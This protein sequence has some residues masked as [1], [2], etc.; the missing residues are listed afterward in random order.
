MAS[1]VDLFLDSLV[2]AP[3]RDE[4]A[5]MEFPFFSITKRPQ[6]EAFVY[7]RDDVKIVVSPGPKGMAT[8]WD[9][10]VLIY[11]ASLLNERLER[12]LPADRKVHFAA[13]D[14]LRVTQR[15]TGKQAYELFKDALFRLRSTTVETTIV[16]GGQRNHRG[17]GWIDT[18]EIIEDE[19]ADG[20]RRM[21]A[22]EISL[23]D[24]MHRAVTKDRRVLSISR[25]YFALTGGLERRLYQL[26]RK[27]V[28]RQKE[29]RILLPA[30]AEKVGS[31][32]EL[33][34][35]KR[36]LK[37]V[38]EADA[39]PDYRFGLLGDPSSELE[40][41]MREDGYKLR[42]AV[43]NDRILVLACPKGR[44]DSVD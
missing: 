44:S 32:Q 38:I 11:I 39:I 2:D 33:R 4:R 36:D 20:S 23:S 9:R 27:H 7:E 15:G 22:V 18:F 19:R 26:A 40:A 41:G 29:W 24:W 28:G 8:I 43:S 12:G 10:D 34:F 42:P 21:R 3:L 14:F 6:K 16:S 30:L 5:L 35:F 1:Q 17:F 37:K 13:H 25:D 31:Q